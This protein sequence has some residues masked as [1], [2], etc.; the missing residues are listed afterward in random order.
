MAHRWPLATLRIACVM[1][2]IVLAGCG[3]GAVAPPDPSDGP[4]TGEVEQ[5]AEYLKGEAAAGKDE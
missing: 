5:S 4:P 2:V 3:G 1:G